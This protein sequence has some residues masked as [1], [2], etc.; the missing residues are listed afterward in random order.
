MWDAN[1]EA[2][3]TFEVT[4][5]EE[6]TP[7]EPLSLS[8]DWD[9]CGLTPPNIDCSMFPQVTIGYGKLRVNQNDPDE[10]IKELDEGACW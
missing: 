7:R 6:F 8:F 3:A 1:D 2:F 5:L 10:V 9:S 4:Q